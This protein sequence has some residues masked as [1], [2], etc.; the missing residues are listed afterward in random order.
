MILKEWG[1]IAVTEVYSILTP[2]VLQFAGPGHDVHYGANQEWYTALWKRKAGCGP[3]V[4]ASLLWYLAHTRPDC[5]GLAP[6]E[7]G[8]EAMTAQ[9]EAVWSY[10]TPGM[11]GVNR[12]DMFRDGVLR[13]AADRGTRL[14][15]DVLNVPPIPGDRPEIAQ[16]AAFLKNALERDLPLA[17]LNL[18][19]GA[20]KRLDNWHWVTIMAFAPDRLMGW[21]YDD[22]LHKEFNLALWLE[23]SP[24]GGG[25]VTLYPMG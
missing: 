20:E 3:T 1:G 4:G 9:M 19:S 14:A 6:V 16:A 22:G 12:T 24:R 7:L 11:R 23:T 18:G 17:F 13:F 10:V 15:C 8:Q 21:I 2:S 5:A 25:F